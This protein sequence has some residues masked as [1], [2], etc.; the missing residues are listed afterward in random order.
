ML[1]LTAEER[2]ALMRAAAKGMYYNIPCI[3][4]RELAQAERDTAL[5][6]LFRMKATVGSQQEISQ[7]GKLVEV[8]TVLL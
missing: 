8:K 6:I 3:E 1:S 5:D 7:E 2:Q 4:T